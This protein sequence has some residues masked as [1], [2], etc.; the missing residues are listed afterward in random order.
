MEKLCFLFGSRHTPDEALPLIETAVEKNYLEYGIRNFVVGGRG[1]FDHLAADAL[2]AVKERHKDIY[3]RL[4]L[5]YHPTDRRIDIPEGFDGTLYPEGMEKVPG[6]F[7]I[8]RAN[9][10]LIR[11]ADSIICYVHQIGNSRELL[12]YAKGRE[13]RGILKV[14]NLT[15]G[16][17]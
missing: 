2:K 13:K 14:E 16:T 5:H 12:E 8:V 11:A 9:Q 10:C 1:N 17:L 7:A 15:K 4:L 3:L 6:K